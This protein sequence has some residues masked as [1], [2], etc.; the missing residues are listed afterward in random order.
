M[1]QPKVRSV[2][3]IYIFLIIGLVI[4]AFMVF[5]QQ[6]TTKPTAIFISDVVAMSQATP[7]QIKSINVQ[8]QNTRVIWIPASAS[9]MLK[10]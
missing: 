7:N 6:P 10:I 1:K 3:F 2:S 9:M 8:G 4:L 5:R